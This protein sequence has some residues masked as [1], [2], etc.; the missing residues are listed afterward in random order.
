MRININEP[1]EAENVSLVCCRHQSLPTETLYADALEVTRG[2]L[3]VS[4]SLHTCGSSSEE[5]PKLFGRASRSLR[6]CWHSGC[7]GSFTCRTRTLA[8]SFLFFS[9]GFRDAIVCWSVD[10]TLVSVRLA[11]QLLCRHRQVDVTIPGK[12]R[13]ERVL[14]NAISIDG[15]KEWTCKFCSESNVWTRWRCRRCYN[16]IPAG[17]HGKYRQAVA[18]KSGE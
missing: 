9:S 2:S 12:E 5:T 15:R 18:A 13:A 4:L 7:P 3:E 14:A 6:I 11:K 10:Q 16:N 1:L 8:M 17:L